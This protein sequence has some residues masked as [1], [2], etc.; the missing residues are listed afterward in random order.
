VPHLFSVTFE[1]PGDDDEAGVAFDASALATRPLPG[2]SDLCIDDV[3]VTR[4]ARPL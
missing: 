1:P 4:E 2:S 3:R